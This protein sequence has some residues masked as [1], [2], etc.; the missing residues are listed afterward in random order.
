MP[1][2]SICV[3]APSKDI[4]L[5]AELVIIFAASHEKEIKKILHEEYSYKGEI[6]CLTEN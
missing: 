6:F 3:E 5:N 2:A 4:F 1:G